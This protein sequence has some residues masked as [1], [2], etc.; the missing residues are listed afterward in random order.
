[1]IKIRQFIITG[2]IV[3]EFELRVS[4]GGTSN[5]S[6]TVANNDRKDNVIFMTV[7]AFGKTAELAS[8]YLGKGSKCLVVGDF[9]TYEYEKD[10][11]KKY[12]YE[13]LA[14]RV[15]FLDSKKSAGEVKQPS[16]EDDESIPF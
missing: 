7:K 15:E 10:G 14:N 1:V 12:G 8:E 11:E 5:C 9:A 3:K 13:I 4:Q 2:N 16:T 6:F